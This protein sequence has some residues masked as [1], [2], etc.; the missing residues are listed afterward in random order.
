MLLVDRVLFQLILDVL[1]LRLRPE[2]PPPAFGLL[3][4][5]HVSFYWPAGSNYNLI[6]MSELLGR[7]TELVNNRLVNNSCVNP[8]FVKKVK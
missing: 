6:R 7:S 3:L 4:S 5:N 2:E 8:Y 1:D